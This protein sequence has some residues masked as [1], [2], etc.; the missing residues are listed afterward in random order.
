MEDSKICECCERLTEEEY[1][2]ANLQLLS[3]IPESSIFRCKACQSFWIC[4][5]ENGWES[6]STEALWRITR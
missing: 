2:H 6:L 5:I 3:Q 1:P 4:S